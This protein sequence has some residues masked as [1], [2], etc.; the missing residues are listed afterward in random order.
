MSGVDPEFLIG[1]GTDPPRGHPTYNFA[2][3]SKKEKLHEIEN[4]WGR[5]G[6]EGGGGTRTA[7][8]RPANECVSAHLVFSKF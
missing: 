8:L 4:I 2:K 7:S 5:D 6:L 1:W 3:F